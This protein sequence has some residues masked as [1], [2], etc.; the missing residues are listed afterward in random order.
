MEKGHNTTFMYMYKQ[1]VYMVDTKE[2]SSVCT[3]IYSFSAQTSA[4]VLLQTSSG[5]LKIVFAYS[6]N[7]FTIFKLVYIQYNCTFSLPEHLFCP[8]TY[9][10]PHISAAID[11]TTDVS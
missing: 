3:W 7:P 2:V 11:Q 9:A 6:D 4:P 5:S 10:N 1:E 8:I